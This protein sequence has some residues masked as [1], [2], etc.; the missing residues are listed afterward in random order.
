[1]GVAVSVGELS[2]KVPLLL[3]EHTVA[4]A[5][6]VPVDAASTVSR[7]VDEVKNPEVVFQ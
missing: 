3:P 6:T 4:F 2:N 1:M 7:A 5:V